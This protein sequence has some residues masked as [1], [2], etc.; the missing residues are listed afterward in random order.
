MCVTGLMPMI[1][2]NMINVPAVAV[3]TDMG[4][5]VAGPLR[6][7]ASQHPTATYSED[8]AIA[9]FRRAEANHR[10]YGW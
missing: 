5:G 10:K 3:R 6:I 9:A 7:D 4:G 1:K 2:Y 8:E